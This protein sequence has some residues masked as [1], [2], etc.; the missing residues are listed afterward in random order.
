MWKSTAPTDQLPYYSTI[1]HLQSFLI[2]WP[3]IFVQLFGWVSFFHARTEHKKWLNTLWLKIQAS[4]GNLHDCFITLLQRGGHALALFAL[5]KRPFLLFKERYIHAMCVHLY[6][7]LYFHLDPFPFFESQ[8]LCERAGTL[9]AYDWLKG[10][11]RQTRDFL[12]SAKIGIFG[13]F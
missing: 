9:P 5:F 6:L 11:M 10:T 8:Q 12:Y 4:E 7:F 1:V 13:Y 3:W 2:I